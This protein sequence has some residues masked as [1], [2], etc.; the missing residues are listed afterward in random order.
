MAPG[1]KQTLR[2]DAICEPAACVCILDLLEPG[3]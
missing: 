1:I 2:F 3:S